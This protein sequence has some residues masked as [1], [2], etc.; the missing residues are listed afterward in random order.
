MN[1]AIQLRI[2]NV[3]LFEEF[4]WPTYRTHWEGLRSCGCML[5]DKPFNKILRVNKMPNEWKRS[6][7]TPV[8]KNKWDIW[9][10]TNYYEIKLM[11]HTVELLG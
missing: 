10:Y 4:G 7:L 6:I 2:E 9:N 3:G 8:Y 5:V 11:S 1:L